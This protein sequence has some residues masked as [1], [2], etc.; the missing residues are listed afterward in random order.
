MRQ[1]MP[2]MSKTMKFSLGIF[3][4]LYAVTRHSGLP[5]V[6]NEEL[7]IT[8]TLSIALSGNLRPVPFGVT[9]FGRVHSTL[10]AGD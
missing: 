2:K 1:R 6:H 5:L 10:K 3:A 7:S 9:A 4:I 8:P